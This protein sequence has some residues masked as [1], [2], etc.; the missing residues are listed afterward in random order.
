MNSRATQ[1]ILSVA[2]I[3]ALLGVPAQAY[4]H[5]VY[6]YTPSFSSP[7]Q[8][9]FDL[10]KLTN[11]TVT[12]FVYD[13][14]PATFYPNDSF[15]SVLGEVKQA[16]AAWNAVPSSSLRV[17][18]GGLET[19]GQNMNT[20]SGDVVFRDLT[21]GLLGMGSP[22]VSAV[23]NFWN[24]GSGLFVPITR[25]TVVL[26][27]NTGN[28]PGPSYMESFFTTAV[29]EIGHALGLQHTWTG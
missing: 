25:S 17:A 21:P 29:H 27:N 2:A 8:A 16:L 23:P 28:A 3:A 18:F 1:R 13:N 7:L 4:Y 12:F 26:T 6:F 19:P 14:G 9:K 22:N 10:V 15:G 24:E 5:Y 20:P 11:S